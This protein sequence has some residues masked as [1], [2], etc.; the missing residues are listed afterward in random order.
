MK[1]HTILLA[2]LLLVSFSCKEVDKLLTFTI[3][4]STIFRVE[5]TFPVSVPLQ[6]ATP[7]IT[8]DSEESFSSHDTRADLVKDIKLDRLDLTAVNPAGRNFNFLKSVK[9]FMSTTSTNE[10]LIASNEDVPA[11]VTIVELTPTTQKLDD[12]IKASSY[13]LR[14]EIVTREAVTQD[15][16]IR[17]S[18]DFKV[19]AD[20]L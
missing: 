2:C 17:V 19:T 7:D 12:Y 6:I 4:H 11:D 8:T 1:I 14:T 3:S 10:L 13:K 5:K 15:V 18:M 9:V 16:D 20:P